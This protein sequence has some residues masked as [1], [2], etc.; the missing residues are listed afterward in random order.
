V[1]ISSFTHTSFSRT[2]VQ[3]GNVVTGKRKKKLPLAPPKGEM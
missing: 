3:R 2:S 1:K